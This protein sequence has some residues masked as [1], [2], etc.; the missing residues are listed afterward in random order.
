MLPLILGAFFM[1]IFEVIGGATYGSCI[2]LGPDNY[3]CH[4]QVHADMKSDGGSRETKM[5]AH[6]AEW[7]QQ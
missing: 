1:G 4:F 7:W 3:Q 5:P 2:L 6:L